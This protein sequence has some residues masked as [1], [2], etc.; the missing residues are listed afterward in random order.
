M[1]AH[2]SLPVVPDKAFISKDVTI[3]HSLQDDLGSPSF[4]GIGAHQV[5]HNGQ[6]STVVSITSLQPK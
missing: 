3:A 4:I 5:G 6:P 2:L 1:P